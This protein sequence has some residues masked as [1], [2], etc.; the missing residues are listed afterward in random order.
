MT[1]AGEVTGGQGAMTDGGGSVGPKRRGNRGGKK[2]RK[3][4]NTGSASEG[5]W[6]R[7]PGGA[8][9]ASGSE[10]SWKSASKNYGGYVASSRKARGW[11]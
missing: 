2:H 4:Q 3:K 8:S 10:G 7:V 11:R 5:S 1:D 6:H 9:G